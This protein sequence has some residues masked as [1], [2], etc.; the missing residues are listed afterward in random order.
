MY[1]LYAKMRIEMS[2]AQQVF[3]LC[4]DPWWLSLVP[5]FTSLNL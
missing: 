2:G 1:P 5:H 3:S 4:P